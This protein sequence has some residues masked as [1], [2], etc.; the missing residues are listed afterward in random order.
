V[1][2]ALAATEWPYPVEALGSAVRRG[3]EQLPRSAK[4]LPLI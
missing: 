1:T 3:Y 4:S 2:D